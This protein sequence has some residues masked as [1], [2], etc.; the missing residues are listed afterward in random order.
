MEWIPKWDSLIPS[1]SAVN[2]VSVT[3]SMRI[4]FPILRSNV[5]HWT[6]QRQAGLQSS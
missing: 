6:M 2:F 5:G 4:L 3:P 1:G